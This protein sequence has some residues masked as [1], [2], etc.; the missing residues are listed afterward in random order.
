M[1]RV[2]EKKKG[3]K[4]KH[5]PY[6][7]GG[8]CLLGILGWILLGDHSSKLKV[9][10]KGLTIAAVE[11]NPFNDYIRLNG[12]VQPGSL[13]QISAMETGIID[14]KFIE[15]GATVRKGDIILRLKNPNLS[16]AILDSEA[17]LA[18]KQNFLRNTQVTM[19]QEKLNLRQELLAVQL[20]MAR[21][22]RA[23]EQNESLYKE[24]LVARE[25]YLQA[26]EDYEYAH[27]R[28]QLITDRQR[29]DSIY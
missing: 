17:Q 3:L 22:K 26:Q 10:K 4:K 27:N 21:K 23:W 12:Q 18:E 29:Q 15:E 20:D 8:V 6:I 14:E 16:L 11:S 19:E 7:I 9:E 5:Y 13:I 24:K 2:I 28:M 1:D 25:T